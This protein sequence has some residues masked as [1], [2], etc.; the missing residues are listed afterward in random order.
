MGC[1]LLFE[2][3]SKG[4][5]ATKRQEHPSGR[6]PLSWADE[7]DARESSAYEGKGN[8]D[9]KFVPLET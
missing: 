2:Y 7:E 9:T 1:R 3:E 6:V 8:I 4:W 5:L